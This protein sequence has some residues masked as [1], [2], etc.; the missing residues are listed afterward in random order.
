MKVLLISANTERT[1]MPVLPV[2]MA[3]VARAAEDAGHEV[4]QLNLM[5]EPEA[6]PSLA[7]RIQM[8]QPDIIGI[9]V[10]NID[11]QVSLNPRFLLEP[12]KKVVDTCKL[13]AGATIVLG[14]AGFSMF[15]NPIL[16]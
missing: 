9:S 10:R 6:L 5:S 16:A 12:V 1:N 2:G 7:A 15:P 4:S 13:N 8:V 11:D 14:G 3:S